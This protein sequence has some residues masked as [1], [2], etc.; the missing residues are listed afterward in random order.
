MDLP[1]FEEMRSNA[2]SHLSSARD[3]L[4][5]DLRPGTHLTDRQAEALTEART[6]AAQ[7]KAALDRA[8]ARA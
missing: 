3:E 2:R 6:L 1:T 8:G 7:A 5:S 4:N